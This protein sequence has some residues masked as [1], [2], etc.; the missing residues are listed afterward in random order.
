MLKML[1]DFVGHLLVVA[2]LRLV[3]KVNTPQTQIALWGNVILL[4]VVMALLLSALFRLRR[5]SRQVIADSARRSREKMLAELQ[6]K[7]EAQMGHLARALREE[8]AGN[9]RAADE[10]LAQLR[11]GDSG[12][13]ARD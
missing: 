7:H 4:A 10:A 2:L 9:T 6:A 11:T 1:L 13:P 5:A 3:V 8:D 12:T